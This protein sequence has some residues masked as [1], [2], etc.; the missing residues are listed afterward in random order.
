MPV[1]EI[2][3]GAAALWEMFGKDM[4]TDEMEAGLKRRWQQFG[5]KKAAETY[6]ERLYAEHSVI[7]PLGSPAPI[8]LDKVFTDVYILSQPK[9]LKRFDIHKLHADPG[10]L[11]K[12]AERIPGLEL[13]Q[14]E[15]HERLFILGGPGA[16]KTTFLKYLT[17]QAAKNKIQKVPIFIS[18]KRWADSG[19]TLMDYLAREFELCNFPDARSF[20]TSILG[21]GRALVLFDGLDEIPQAEEQQRDKAIGELRDFARQYYASPCLITCRRAAVEYTF[22]QFTYV[23]LADFTPEQIRDMVTKWFVDDP[24]KSDLFFADFDRK[25]NRGVRELARTP[26]LLSL[27]CLAFEQNA[28]FPQRRVEIYHNAIEALLRKWDATRNIRRDELA[29]AEQLYKLMSPDRKHQMLAEVAIRT[30]IAG[31]YFIDQETLEGRLVEYVRKLP[32]IEP[33]ADIDG[34]VLLRA[35]EAQHG[36][37]VTRAER[38]HSFAH[39]SFQEYFAAMAIKEE[40][41]VHTFEQLFQ[42]FL[43]DNRW[44]EVFLLTA[45]AL[46]EA[47]LFLTTFRVAVDAFIADDETLVAVAH[48]ADRQAQAVPVIAR[49]DQVRLYW[50]AVLARG[51]AIEIFYLSVLFS[52]RDR[53]IGSSSS[54]A[55]DIARK[56]IIEI[57]KDIKF[58]GDYTI[59][60]GKDLDTLSL[61]KARKLANNS[62]FS[63]INSK[64]KE[65]AREVCIVRDITNYCA[66]DIRQYYTELIQLMST[67]YTVQIEL[68]EQFMAEPEYPLLCN[69]SLPQLVPDLEILVATTRSNPTPALVQAVTAYLAALVRWSRGSCYPGLDTAL[70]ALVVPAAA[71]DDAAWEVFEQQIAQLPEYINHVIGWDLSEQQARRLGQYFQA[72]NLLEDCLDVA[73]AANRDEI[74][75]SLLLPPGE[76]QPGG[77]ESNWGL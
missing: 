40:A 62:A 52:L 33:T 9:A 61:E 68:L 18:L 60:T 23:E 74:R 57:D 75:A 41:S 17:I 64:A 13:V 15:R 11:D 7:R 24:E 32:G 22:E 28:S 34:R 39:L 77:S 6:L 70:A 56:I 14:R 26:L 58:A 55:I 35:I 3:A 51:D 4:Y 42:Q 21:K 53:T 47:S 54:R 31:T 38:V 30:F 73:Y 27:L 59:E 49:S 1:V 63:G 5:W 37:L 44:R 16:G 72:V 29:Y 67:M 66:N 65:F 69:Y 46:K 2:I 71:A 12:D 48:W 25:E 8:E 19:L 45:S 43:S 36:I 10:L 20:I 76:W 50:S